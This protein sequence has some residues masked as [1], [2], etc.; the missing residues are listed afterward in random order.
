MFREGDAGSSLGAETPQAS[1]ASVGHSSTVQP[2]SG[3]HEESD[4]GFTCG[5]EG[6]GEV[7]SVAKDGRDD[8]VDSELGDDGIPTTWSAMQV[9]GVTTSP[10][11]F[12]ESISM[13]FWASG[14]GGVGPGGEVG[15]GSS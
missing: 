11:L 5:S 2:S 9:W 4:V 1:Q 13:S 6:S 14:A 15:C 7:D 3:F 10:G 12:E 8:I